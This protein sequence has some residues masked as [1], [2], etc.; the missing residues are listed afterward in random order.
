MPKYLI[1]HNLVSPYKTLMFNA[2]WDLTDEFMV[3]NIAETENCREWDVEKDG[4]RFPMEI[5]FKGNVE[6]VEPLRA[7]ART[8]S[9]LNYFNPE[10]VMVYGYAY[11]SYW[12][13]WIW[14]LLRR[15]RLAVLVESQYCDKPR[16]VVKEFVKRLFIAGCDVAFGAGTMHR[17]YLVGLG[18]KAEKV[19]IVNGVGGV[20]NTY[21]GRILEDFKSNAELRAGLGIPEHNFLFVGR[22]SPEKNIMT[23]LKAY[24]ALRQ[25][26][27]EDWGLILV[28][29]GPQLDEISAFIGEYNLSDVFMPGFRQKEELVRFYGA[30][31][32]LI[33][34]SLSEPW[35]LVVDEALTCGMPVIV[36]NKCG[37]APDLV[38]E[39]ENGFTF[40][41]QDVEGLTEIMSRFALGEVNIEKMGAASREIIESFT[42]QNAAKSVLKGMKFIA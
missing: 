36:S 4:A 33:L 11:P 18:M 1:L 42:P 31:D 22:F 9:R 17:N 2:L 12:T 29:N 34:P 14:C 19:F 30:A 20:D 39:G 28:G 40:D 10:V 5:M 15:R 13:A 21:F 3:L 26:T 6:D 32:V 41:P 7:V 27:G 35:G 25:R 37:S 38:K 23:L 24:R 8:F 16:H